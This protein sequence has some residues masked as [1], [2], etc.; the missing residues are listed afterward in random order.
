MI[1]TLV[2]VNQVAEA[3]CVYCGKGH[4][5]NNCL[6]NRSSINYIGNFNRQNQNNPYSNTYNPELRQHLNFSWNNQNQHAAA[7]SGQNR[8][9]QPPGFHQ[10]NQG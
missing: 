10:Q 4:L 8:S 1:T 2:T 7:I 3:S 5:F 9:A 6:E